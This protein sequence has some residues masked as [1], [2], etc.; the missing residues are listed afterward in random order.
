MKPIFKELMS[1]LVIPAVYNKNPADYNNL[2]NF[3]I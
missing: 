3:Q 1:I 2:L